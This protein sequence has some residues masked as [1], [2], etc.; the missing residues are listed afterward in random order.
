[1]TN[2]NLAV[3]AINIRAWYVEGGVHPTRPPQ[4]LALGKFGDPTKSIGEAAKIGAPDPNSFNRDV[5]VGTVEGADERATFSVSVR[6]TVQAAI[7]MAMKNKR[8]RVDWFALVG[9]CGNPQDFTEGG[10]KWVYFPDGKMSQQSVENFGAFDRGENNP[11]NE[12]ADFTSEDYWEYLMMSQEAVGAAYTTRQIYTVDVYTGNECENCPDPCDRVLATMAGV[13][14]TPGTKPV[15][16]YSDD[17]S[18]TFS[19]DIITTLHSNEEVSDGAVVG[20]DIVYISNTSCSIHWTDIELL[21]DNSNTWSEVLSGFVATK[22]P[23]AISAADPRHIWIVG[24][25][26]YV[27]FSSNHKTGVSVQDAGVVTTQHLRAV[28]ALDT[29]NVLAAGDSNA[30][31]YTK[32]GGVS[33][34]SV[35]GPSVGINMGACWMWDEATWFVGEGAGG[36]GKLWLTTNRGNS[37]TEVG[38][39]AAYVRIY[40]IQFISE[41][42][43]FLLASDGSKTY[44]LRTITAGNEWVVLPQG[45]KAVAV[46]NTF[47]TDLAVCSKT[48]NTAYAGGLAPNG[49]AGIIVKMSG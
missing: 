34:Q 7:L 44:V 35:T 10:E 4:F 40:K 41:A 14:A 39:P 6:Y 38:L 8:C 1:M 46:D 21:Y 30:V 17:G 28:H 3:S 23:N 32:N 19:T 13:G 36:T 12:N 49:T 42:E 26:G 22:C 37:W 18:E 9:K 47:L 48:G 29:K 20:G 43:G 25:G 11:A 27:Y 24:D 15:L 16:L 2:Q 31:V 33:W 45:K 5:Q